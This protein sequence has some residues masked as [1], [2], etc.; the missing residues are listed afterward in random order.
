MNNL[1]LCTYRVWRGG[2][3]SCS[4]N[5]QLKYLWG[6]DIEGGIWHLRWDRTDEKE[7][8]IPVIEGRIQTCETNAKAKVG[9]SLYTQGQKEGQHA[10]NRVGMKMHIKPWINKTKD[11]IE[12]YIC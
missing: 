9:M 2:W 4:E 10:L 7:S 5:V 11:K 8:V 3:C 6:S 1:I 12:K